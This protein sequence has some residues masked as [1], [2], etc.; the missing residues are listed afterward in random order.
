QRGHYCRPPKGEDEDH[1]DAHCEHG[2]LFT[3]TVCLPCQR[4][5]TVGHYGVVHDYRSVCG[6]RRHAL[7][8]RMYHWHLLRDV[9]D[10]PKLY[11]FIKQKTSTSR[12]CFNIHME[13]QPGLEPGT[14]SLPWKCS[15]TELSGHTTAPIIPIF[16]RFLKYKRTDNKILT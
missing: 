6:R 13:P 7:G 16:A 3:P 2:G 4:K 8:W 11:N 15:T 10:S 9:D 12:A 5:L 14:P 1:R